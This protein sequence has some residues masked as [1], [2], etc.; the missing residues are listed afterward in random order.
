MVGT[1]PVTLRCV[2]TGSDGEDIRRQCLWLCDSQMHRESYSWNTVLKE[3]QHKVNCL[4]VSECRGEWPILTDGFSPRLGEQT[5]FPGRKLLRWRHSQHRCRR[6][7]RGANRNRMGQEVQLFTRVS[8]RSIW[9]VLC[10]SKRRDKPGCVSTWN[11]KCLLNGASL[12][13]FSLWG[14]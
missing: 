9:T 7:H 10:A 13:F 5:S 6:C 2:E 11:G 4:N 12:F 8:V 3:E 14:S 1:G